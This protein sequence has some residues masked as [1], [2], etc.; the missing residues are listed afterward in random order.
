MRGVTESMAGRAAILQ[1][2]PLSSREIAKVDLLRGG[3][4]EVF[5]PGLACHLLGIDTAAELRKSPFRGALFEGLVASEIAKRSL[6]GAADGSSTSIATGRGWR[7]TSSF[8]GREC[9][10]TRT[11]TPAMTTP[12][13]RLREVIRARR[14]KGTRVTMRLVHESP[15]PAAETRIVAPGV[16]ALPWREFAAGLA[17]PSDRWREP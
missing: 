8:R 1:L 9:K 5:D 14:P 15:S 16:R 2:L 12:M 10:A 13:R 11:V 4:P 3:Y 6:T 7:L 17:P